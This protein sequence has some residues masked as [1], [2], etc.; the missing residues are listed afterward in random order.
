MNRIYVIEKKTFYNG[1]DPVIELLKPCYANKKEA[2]EMIKKKYKNRARAA[3]VHEHFELICF[4]VK[5]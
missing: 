3:D 5:E 1:T 4:P 2:N